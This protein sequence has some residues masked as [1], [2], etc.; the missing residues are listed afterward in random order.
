MRHAVDLLRSTRTTSPPQAA[1]VRCPSSLWCRPRRLCALLRN[2]PQN[3]AWLAAFALTVASLLR[4]P[5][6]ALCG[7]VTRASLTAA[8]AL[9]LALP[10]A[11][12][13]APTIP[14]AA[15]GHPD[16]NGFWTAAPTG[17]WDLQNPQTGGGRLQVAIDATKGLPE[18][19]KPSRIVDPPDGRIPYQPWA[20]AKQKE[21]AA[22]VDDPVKPE[23][24]DTQARCLLDGVMRPFF[25]GPVRI[26]QTADTLAVL[27][28]DNHG[29]RTISLKGGQHPGKDIHLWMGDSRGTW[30]GNTLVVDIA[31]L[32]GKP[33]LDMV[34]NFYSPTAHFVERFTPVD[35]NTIGYEVTVE[36]P[37]VYTR[38]W[39]VVSKLVRAHKNEPN[40]EIWEDSCHEG[41]QSADAM[42]LRSD[43]R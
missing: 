11:P 7:L 35:A 42:V 29:F 24:V 15:D 27:E 36:D 39:K 19:P 23:H 22:H 17:T 3:G 43:V 14:L 38:P 1:Y 26:E 20:A 30:E 4:G 40:Y 8:A 41:E 9:L 21:I 2:R 13:T 10:A 28:E 12:Q 33:R 5:R 25:H 37:S 18:K 34:A 31:N 32:N 6:S 16:L